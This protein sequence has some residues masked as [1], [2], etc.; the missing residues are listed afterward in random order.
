[1]NSKENQYFYSALNNINK[2]EY[3]KAIEDLLKVIELDEKNLDAYYNLAAVYYDIKDY[4]N[5]IKT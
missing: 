3:D 2:K 1:M 5:A 4:D